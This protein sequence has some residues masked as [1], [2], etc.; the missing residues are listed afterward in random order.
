MQAVVGL[1]PSRAVINHHLGQL[2]L[3]KETTY[4]LTLLSLPSLQGRQIEYL[5]SL[6]GVKAGYVHLCRVAS[7]IV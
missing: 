2:G 4:L 5:P 6:A 1:T 7:N 3:E